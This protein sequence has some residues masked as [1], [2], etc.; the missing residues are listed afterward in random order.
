[1]ANP[2]ILPSPLAKGDCIGL[3]APAGPLP[4]EELLSKGISLIESLGFRV[5]YCEDIIQR[6]AYLAGSDQRRINEFKTL[7]AD[8]EVQA[9]LAVRGGY[10]SVR[11]LA[12]L[13]FAKI[14][15]TPKIVMGFS[16]LTALLNGLQA[17]TGLVT[18]HGP[19]LSTMVRDQ[20]VLPSDFLENLTRSSLADRTSMDIQI[21]RPGQA[22]GRLMGGN[23]TNL[24]HMIG[25]PYEPDWQDTI[26]F[27][28]DI[29]EPAYKIDRMFTHL[30]LAGR[31]DKVSGVL[32]GEFSSSSGESIPNS[33][34]TTKRLLKVTPPHVP[35]WANFPVGHGPKNHI[36]PIGVKAVMDSTKRT[37]HF[38]GSC[39]NIPSNR[40]QA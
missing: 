34:L 26:L 33:D 8:K 23:L 3:F 29:N 9:L 1:M 13:D 18:F 32:L 35:V 2:V 15:K 31:L 11:V 5:K 28:E 37:L 6:D 10:G 22:S 39:L 30:H 12:A 38:A 36:M 7:W 20:T 16:D 14:R 40:F 17:K 4:S 21:L 19:M 25:T 24:V 27:L